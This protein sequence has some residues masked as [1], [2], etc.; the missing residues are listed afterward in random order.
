MK[1][2]VVK[3]KEQGHKGSKVGNFEYKNKI[4]FQDF[5]QLAL[6][7]QDLERLGAKVEKAFTEFRKLK[8]KKTWPF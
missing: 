2:L 7:L 5:K 6:F 3:V 4:V 1:V 8:E